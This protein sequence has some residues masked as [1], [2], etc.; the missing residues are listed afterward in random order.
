MAS[1]KTAIRFM[2]RLGDNLLS[3][4]RLAFFRPVKLKQFSISLD[5][6]M[7]LVLAAA[8]LGVIT[9]LVP[10][11]LGA[12]FNVYALPSTAFD[13]ALAITAAY[14]IAKIQKKPSIVLALFVIILSAAPVFSVLVMV[15]SFVILLWRNI[16]CL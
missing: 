15:W 8:A 16:I 13:L 12:D 1:K 3:G 10:L 5:Q 2:R 11:G 4:L 7:G 14:I 9:D 6:A